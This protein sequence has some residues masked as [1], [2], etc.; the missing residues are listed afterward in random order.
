M[1]TWVEHGGDWGGWIVRV[2]EGE[3]TTLAKITDCTG[4]EFLPQVL[5]THRNSIP[6]GLANVSTFIR[7]CV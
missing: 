4:E 7:G 6:K 3:V 5:T 1:A 2:E